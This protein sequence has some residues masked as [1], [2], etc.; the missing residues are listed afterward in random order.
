MP[1]AEVEERMWLYLAFLDWI[2]QWVYMVTVEN[3]MEMLQ[4]PMKKEWV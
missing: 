1:K 2:L 3:E 4:E